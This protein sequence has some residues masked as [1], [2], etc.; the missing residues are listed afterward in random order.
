MILIAIVALFIILATLII[1]VPKRPSALKKAKAGG[2]SCSASCGALLPVNEPDFNARE[3]IK[4]VLLLEQHLAEKG[5]YCKSCCVKHF[6][7]VS[8]LLEEG[9]WMS[10]KRCAEYPKL[11]ESVEFFKNLFKEWHDK[12]DDEKT[13]LEV[14]DKLRSWRREMVDLYYFEPGQSD[15]HS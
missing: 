14:L 3:A 9:V 11:E 5:K 10:C 1:L 4:Q 15:S 13:R 6:L 12:M 7:L 2:G 8:G